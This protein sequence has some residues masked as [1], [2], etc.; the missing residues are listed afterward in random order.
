FLRHIVAI[1]AEAEGAVEAWPDFVS[2][3]ATVPNEVLDAV[4]PAT[5]T[6][7]DG[8]IIYSSGTTSLPKGV[9]HRH[10]APMLQS[11]RH[12]YREQFGPEDRV[13]CGLPWF[14]TAGFAA[15]LGATLASGGTVIVSDS[16]SAA[17]AIKLIE[18]ERVTCVQA[19]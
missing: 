6:V 16:F 14:W 4:V 19:L 1:D 7:E 2:G 17:H 5:V 9:L 18:Q 8:I 13:L 12:A 3:G 15:V 11:W 10:R